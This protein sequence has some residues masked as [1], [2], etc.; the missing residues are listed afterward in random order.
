MKPLY[1][2]LKVHTLKLRVKS[3]KEAIKIKKLEIKR[4]EKENKELKLDIKNEIN[5][6]NHKKPFIESL[7]NLSLNNLKNKGE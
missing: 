5:L 2:V 3:N 4:L 6:D 1:D 7:K